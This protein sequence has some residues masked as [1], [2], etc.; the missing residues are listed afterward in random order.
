MNT[1]TTPPSNFSQNLSRWFNQ[2]ILWLSR[3]WLAVANTFFFVYVG[4]PLL[5]PVL[6][7]TGFT[8]AANTI[9]QLYNMVCHQL[10]TRAYFILGEQVPM[11][12]RCI[13]I[14]ATLFAGGVIFN[15]AR[16]RP[17]PARWYLLF[18]LPMALDGGSAF[19]SELAQVVPLWIFW[20]LWTLLTGLVITGLYLQKM[21]TWQV[22]IVFAGGFLA[23]AYLQFVGL[24]ISNTPIRTLTAVIFG[25]GT[26]WFAYPILED[27]FKDTVNSIGP[28]HS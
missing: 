16:V 6:L 7:A 24:R 27:G 28:H 15:I 14:Y 5:A 8:K 12:E 25:V 4:M 22:V 21:L 10:P 17:L 20:G 9:Y 11:C 26:V 18:A 2:R 13:A 23:L 19:V 1:A 3:H